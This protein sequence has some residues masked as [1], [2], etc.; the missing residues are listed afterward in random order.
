MDRLE[1]FLDGKKLNTNKTKIM[2][3]KKRKA[4]ATK[5]NWSSKENRIEEVKEFRYLKYML[6]TYIEKE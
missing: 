6:K 5:I 3:C 2:R 1:R 4:R